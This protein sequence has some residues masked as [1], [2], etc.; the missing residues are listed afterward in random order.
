MNLFIWLLQIQKTDCWFQPTTSCHNEHQLSIQPI[1]LAYPLLQTKM[2]EVH[3]DDKWVIQ[4]LNRGEDILSYHEIINLIN[5]RVDDSGERLWTFKKIQGHKHHRS[6]KD[7]WKVKVLW[8]NGETPWEPLKRLILLPWLTM[9]KRRKSPSL[10][11]GDG[12]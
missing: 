11:D 8:D 1:W 5:R 7:K 12:H 10:E 4:F 6:R 3:R 9:Q 2:M